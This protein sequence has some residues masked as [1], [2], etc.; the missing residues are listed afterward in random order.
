MCWNIRHGGGARS[1]R[2][3]ATIK[4]HRPDIIVL[5]EF[6]GKSAGILSPRRSF[7]GWSDLP[8]DEPAATEEKR[9]AERLARAVQT[10]R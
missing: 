5:T 4:A 6:P 7:D 9:R 8:G 2:I 10:M 1:G 3:H